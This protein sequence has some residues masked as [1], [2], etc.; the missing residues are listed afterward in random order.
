MR[1]NTTFID[2]HTDEL[3]VVRESLLHPFDGD[4]PGKS[5]AAVHA[6]CIDVCHATGGETK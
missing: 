4:D 5:S 2:K 6:R 1:R 3:G